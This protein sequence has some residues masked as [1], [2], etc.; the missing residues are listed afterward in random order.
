M[1]GLGWRT[2]F[3]INVPVGLMALYLARSWVPESRAERARPFDFIGLALFTVGLAA[4]ILPLVQGQ[5]A[6]WPMWCWL[7]LL[8]AI[9][10]LGAFVPLHVWLAPPGFGPLLLPLRYPPRVRSLRVF[11]AT[12]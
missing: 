3:L 4:L 5:A 6:A 2:V 9:P 1:F 7:S 8:A 12:A 11:T 10:T